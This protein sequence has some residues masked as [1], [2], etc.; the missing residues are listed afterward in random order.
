MNLL[1]G[2]IDVLLILGSAYILLKVARRLRSHR[3]MFAKDIVL[4]ML[5]IAYIV[6][7][8][9]MHFA[10]NWIDRH[11]ISGSLYWAIQQPDVQVIYRLMVGGSICAV[12]L[13]GSSRKLEHQ[14]IRDDVQYFRSF[15]ASVPLY[16]TS[17]VINLVYYAAWGILLAVPLTV[18]LSP[19]PGAYLHYRSPD[20]R[21]YANPA[22]LQMHLF[23]AFAALAGIGSY[24]LIVWI[25]MRKTRRFL[26]VAIVLATILALLACHIHGKRAVVFMLIMA[27]MALSYLEGIARLRHLLVTAVLFLVFI[28]LYAI[29]AKEAR[30]VSITGDIFRHYTLLPVI[31]GSGLTDHEAMP[32]GSGFM[33]QWLFW[34]PRE[35]WPEKPW[36]TPVY[37]TPWIIGARTQLQ[38]GFGL[39]YLEDGFTNFGYL[40]ALAYMTVVLLVCRLSDHLIYRKRGAIY[41][42]LWL[43]IAYGCVFAFSVLL[44]LFLFIVIPV[45][46]LGKILTKPENWSSD[47]FYTSQRKFPVERAEPQWT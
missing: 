27:T 15:S 42:V 35:M 26:T 37:V 1:L 32:R 12:Y 19:T 21:F 29:F 45:L 31:A 43:P 46:L 24:I 5:F 20:L 6:P 14:L 17:G 38:W 9:F 22:A 47:V 2:T 36:P 4:A 34:M 39:G 33:F 10:E 28:Q 23:I 3:I 7:I 16:P 25:E 30:T 44:Q 18:L 41:A 40:G 8:L 13:L 11:L